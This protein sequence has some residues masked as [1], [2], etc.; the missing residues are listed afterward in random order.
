M[1]T[2]P[3]EQEKMIR[4][5]QR[6]IDR[7]DKLVKVAAEPWRNGGEPGQEQHDGI[8]SSLAETLSKVQDRTGDMGTI[9]VSVRIAEIYAR[10][11][12]LE[13]KYQDLQKRQGKEV[14]PFGHMNIGA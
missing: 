9:R 8:R 6:C 10:F 14:T 4:R 3:T 7:I 12:A 11:L 1:Q 2:Q 5:I 13:I